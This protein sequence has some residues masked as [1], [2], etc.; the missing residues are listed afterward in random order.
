KKIGTVG[1]SYGGG[2]SMALGALKNRIMLPDG[3]YAP[4]KSPNGTDMEIAAAAPIVPWTDFAYSLLPN[5]RTLD[6]A[7]DAPYNDPPGIMKIGIASALLPSG[8]SFS[9]EIRTSPQPPLGDLNAATYPID[10]EADILGWKDRMEVGEPYNDALSDLMFD[11]MT[12]HHSSYYIEDSV[13]PS[14]MLIAQGFTDDLFPVDEPLRYLNRTKSNFPDADISL[15]F[16][17]IGHPRAPIAGPGIS[18]G[19]DSDKEMGFE[20]VDAWFEHYL[21]GNGAKPANQVEVKTQVCPYEEP[22]G[23]PYTAPTWPG[24]SPGEI[25]FE[26]PTEHVISAGAG[27]DGPVFTFSSL[28]PGCGQVDN[29]VEPGTVNYEIGTV[30]TGGVTLMGAPT[31]IADVAVANGSESQIAVRLLEIDSGNKERLISRAAYRPDASGPQVIQLHGNGYKF[32]AGTKI[33]LQLLPKDGGD[34]GL[35]SYTR[36]SNNQ[37][38]VTIKDVDVRLPVMEQP[39]AA[40]GMVTA[41]QPKVLPAGTELAG[42]YAGIGSITIA[43]WAAGDVVP[44]V[45]SLKLQGKPVVKGKVLIAKVKCKAINDSCAKTKLKFKGAPKKGKKGKGLLIAKGNAVAKK[46]GQTKKVKLKLTRKARNFFKDRTFRKNGKKKVKRGPKS[47]RAKVLING[48][49]KGSTNVK[50]VGRVK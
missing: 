10:P 47:L 40:D 31:I 32:K 6:Y 15:L 30:P 12:R 36:P 4:W 16:A 33:R 38:D 28:N 50:R 39:G 24:L 20:R 27:L 5:G 43:E 7:K 49:S 22:S 46:S 45:G 25:H 21:L 2:K 8:D 48:K 34:I 26:D 3:S 13:E 44:V 18:Q 14:P 37:M 35:T 9:G 42:D 11:Q 19:R 41:P 23:G 17:D 1:A 29:T